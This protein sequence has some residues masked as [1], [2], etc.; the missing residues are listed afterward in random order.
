[1]DIHFKRFY[2]FG[3][4]ANVSLLQSRMAGKYWN[5]LFETVDRPRV[6]QCHAEIVACGL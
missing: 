5:T 3:D 4:V 2:T 6:F 1:M